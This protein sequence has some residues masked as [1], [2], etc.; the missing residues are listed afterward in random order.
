[1]ASLET[2][3]TALFEKSPNEHY[4]GNG[5][6]K[7]NKINKCRQKHMVLISLL[8]V[9]IVVIVFI[10]VLIATGIITNPFENKSKHDKPGTFG[11][12][13]SY[14]GGAKN[15]QTA[16][17]GANVLIN[18][19]NV[20]NLSVVCTQIIENGVENVGYITVDDENNAYITNG[21]PAAT[22]GPFVKKL[23]VI[24]I[25]FLFSLL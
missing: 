11:K 1:M 24:Y 13:S 6:I 17:D 21:E 12:W 2:D 25:Q 16:P 18:E 8:I 10:S 14:G 7:L 15:Q 22:A 3:K 4:A 9:I 5:T 19:E 23:V 20:G